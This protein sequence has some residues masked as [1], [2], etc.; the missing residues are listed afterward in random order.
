MPSPQ[1]LTDQLTLYYWHPQ[2]FSPSGIT[3][4]NIQGP[5]THIDEF[6]TNIFSRL[7]DIT[8]KKKIFLKS[9]DKEITIF[10]YL[11]NQASCPSNFQQPYLNKSED[12]NKPASY[13]RLISDKNAS[14]EKI[15]TGKSL[16]EAPIF[17]STNT[18][19]DNRLFMEIVSLKYLQNVLLNH[20]KMF[21]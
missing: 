3:A 13:L 11:K 9:S 14:T 20:E 4:S 19:Y 1:Y 5:P 12:K 17:A 6:Q 18:Q 7:D 16:S 2:F 10:T 8:T 15:Y 21:I